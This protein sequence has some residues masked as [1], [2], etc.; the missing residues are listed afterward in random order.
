[1]MVIHDAL[2]SHVHLVFRVP[3]RAGIRIGDWKLLINASESIADALSD[4][5]LPAKGTKGKTAKRKARAEPLEKVA[6]YN[7]ASDVAETTNLASREPERVAA[8]KAKLDELLRDAVRP[9]H[10]VP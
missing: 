1:M 8:M 7:L 2:L 3:G 9:G 6:L 10:P 5:S 4:A